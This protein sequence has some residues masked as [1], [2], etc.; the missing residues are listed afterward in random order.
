MTKIGKRNLFLFAAGLTLAGP[1]AVLLRGAGS[2]S[3]DEAQYP[4]PTRFAEE[5]QAFAKEDALKPPPH[6]A[7]VCVGSSSMRM[8][9]S[10]IAEDLA[11]LTV[12]PR[13]FGGS[14]VNDLLYYLE[15]LVLKYE[16]RA[17]LVYEGDNDIAEGISP[18]RIADG[19][20]KL[21][22][23]IHDKLP[24]CRIYLL[25]AKPSVAREK[26]WPKMQALNRKLVDLC[27]SDD[28]LTF[29]DTASGMLTPDGHPRPDIFRDD[30]LHMKRAGYEIWRAAIRP[31]L[32]KREEKYE[33]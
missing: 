9:H 8:W 30:N 21:V 14:T 3:A 26:M 2:E 31:V 15:P 25:P 33:K 29:I 19:Y 23:R 13:G 10:T 11:P 27:S 24:A 20:K 1:L 16:P 18:D 5:V 7:V 28:R 12:I 32:V 6:G 4:D 17:V 22:A